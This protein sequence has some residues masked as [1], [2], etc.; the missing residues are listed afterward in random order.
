MALHINIEQLLS[1]R[2]IESNRIEFKEGWNPA[3]IYRTICAFANDFDNI[4]GGYIIVGVRE[5]EGIAQRPVCGLEN[6]QIDK[7]QKE[8]LQFNNLIDPVYH[9]KVSIEDIDNRKVLVIWVPGG[10]NRPYKVPD[11]VKAKNKTSNYYIRYNSS[12]IIAKGENE[13]ELIS[14]CNQIPFDDRVNHNANISDISG[15][16]VRDFLVRTKSRLVDQLDSLGLT[17]ILAK[18]DL[19]SGPQERLLPK[20]VALMLFS[21]EPWRF[22]PYTQVDIVI[23]PEGKLENPSNLIEILPIKGPVHLMIAEV[24]NYLKVNV[25]KEKILKLPN[26]AEAVKFCNYPY[27]ALEEA[28]VNALYHRNYQEREPVEISIHPDKIEII[29]YNGPDRSIRISDLREGLN[30]RARRYRNRKLGDYLK[31]LDLTEGR[32]TGIPTIQ[33]E[34]QANNSQRA[35]FETDDER[36]YFLVEIPCHKDFVNPLVHMPDQNDLLYIRFEYKYLHK[37]QGILTFLSSHE[38]KRG[39]TLEAVGISDNFYNKVKYINALLDYGLIEM[40]KMNLQDP[41]QSYRITEKGLRYLDLLKE[42]QLFDGD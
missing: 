39:E 42:G 16:L 12:S 34:L 15:V 3:P 10:S 1:A 35:I 21:Y 5:N 26:Q 41:N 19:I 20:N 7:I 28:V 18:M 24:L 29:S 6:E 23:Y 11:D 25:I 22:F 13:Q 27:Q 4:G 17:D 31:E 8:I 2:T 30:I 33:K 38:G 37:Y 40:T 14:L 32:G 36:T 9:S